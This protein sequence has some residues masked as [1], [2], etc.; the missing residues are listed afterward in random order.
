MA[1]YTAATSFHYVD[2]YKERPTEGDEDGRKQRAW[3]RCL[4]R[5]VQRRHFDDARTEA[6]Y[7]R[8]MRPHDVSSVRCVIVVLLVILTGLSTLGFVYD[9]HV[10]ARA[11]TYVTLCVV[12]LTLLVI[13]HTPFARKPRL[14]VVVMATLFV[15][16]ASYVIVSLPFAAQHHDNNAWVRGVWEATVVVL[17]VYALLPC[18]LVVAI[19]T[20]VLLPS[21]QVTVCLLRTPV[22]DWHFWQ[23]VSND[24]P[25]CMLCTINMTNFAAMFRT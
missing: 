16:L 1:S 2:P 7:E 9:T 13:V 8:Y 23:Q 25:D 10:T 24:N 4:Q 21:A 18:Q 14:F 5:L 11:V 12:L 6:L 20:G 17:A 22:Y 3:A 19:A 15:V